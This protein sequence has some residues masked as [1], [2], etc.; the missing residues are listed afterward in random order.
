MTGVLIAE[1]TRLIYFLQ[2]CVGQ[3]NWCGQQGGLAGHATWAR[4]IVNIINI[5][6]ATPLNII[7]IA[8]LIPILI[9]IIVNVSR[10][11]LSTRQGHAHDTKVQTYILRVQRIFTSPP[12]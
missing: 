7:D 1:I 12:I 5:T 6:I 9:I 3:E 2:F 4:I 8:I 10:M 11:C